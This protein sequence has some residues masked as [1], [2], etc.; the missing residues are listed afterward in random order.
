[1]ED[2]S[3]ENGVNDEVR[4][5]PPVQAEDQPLPPPEEVET[6]TITNNLKSSS[7]STEDSNNRTSEFPSTIDNISIA[8]TATDDSDQFSPSFIATH[9]KVTDYI[10]LTPKDNVLRSVGLLPNFKNFQ[11]LVK[12]FNPF[13]LEITDCAEEAQRPNYNLSRMHSLVLFTTSISQQII[14]QYKVHSAYCRDIITSS[15]ELYDLALS[16]QSEANLKSVNAQ[17]AP[18]KL[19][20]QNL[21]LSSSRPSSA[22]TLKRT[23]RFSTV[24]V[25]GADPDGGMT[26]HHHHLHLQIIITTITPK[27]AQKR[28]PSAIIQKE[29]VALH[30]IQILTMMMKNT[31]IL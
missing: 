18:W 15:A 28:S 23:P 1:M 20:Q 17:N 12:F 9:L 29:E 14:D 8:K 25:Y 6:P 2:E 31:G 7:S 27:A 11:D 10:S 22:S 5:A 30:L 4:M 13:M 3:S 24:T 16:N 26:T 21:S 19:K